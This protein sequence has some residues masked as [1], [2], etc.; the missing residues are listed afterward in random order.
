MI[1]FDALLNTPIAE[2][3][4]RE[5]FVR[6][7]AGGVSVIK[8]FDYRRNAASEAGGGEAE[9]QAFEHTGGFRISE[10]PSIKQGDFIDLSVGTFTIDQIDP[11]DTGWVEVGLI[12]G[13]V[14]N[15]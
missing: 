13:E 3:L 1:D 11:D 2:A 10:A 7:R 8:K 12:K 9:F 4:G 14:E 15:V 5:A 6:H